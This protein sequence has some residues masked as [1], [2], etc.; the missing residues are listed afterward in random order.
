MTP[1][2]ATAILTEWQRR[3][4]DE[5][6]AAFDR[7]WAY[8]SRTITELASTEATWTITT[9]E[10]HESLL[11]VG[12]GAFAVVAFSG[13]PDAVTVKGALHPLDEGIVRV[14]FS[15][16]FAV[17]EVDV[18]GESVRPIVRRWAIDWHGRKQVPIEY[19]LPFVKAP[20]DDS[21]LQPTLRHHNRQRTAAHRLAKAAGWPMPDQPVARAV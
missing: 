12:D 2:D 16:Q 1:A 8:L 9:H 20:R 4:G 13:P 7:A 3:A 11:L 5:R 15:D 14:S 6:A 17:D 19:W 10:D 18:D 21:P